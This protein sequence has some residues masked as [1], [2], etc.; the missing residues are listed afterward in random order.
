[1]RKLV[2][3][4]GPLKAD[5]NIGMLLNRIKAAQIGAELRRLGF[6]VIVPHLESVFTEDT[7]T[8]EAWLAHGIAVMRRCDAVVLV[9]RSEGSEGTQAEIVEAISHGISIYKWPDHPKNYQK[10]Y[11]GWEAYHKLEKEPK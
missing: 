2:Y 9:P 10:R 11:S 6:A 4:A 1:M 5:S 8:E 7:L 3:V